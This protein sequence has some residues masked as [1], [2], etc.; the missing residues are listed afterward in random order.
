MTWLWIWTGLMAFITVVVCVIPWRLI[1]SAAQHDTTPGAG[2]GYVGILFLYLPFAAVAPAVL[3]ALW[4]SGYGFW[5]RHMTARDRSAGWRMSKV[6]TYLGLAVL[7]A[8]VLTFT[9]CNG[10]LPSFVQ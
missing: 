5:R 7:A 1:R 6:F 2:L 10:M 4:L 9:G 3:A 8:Y